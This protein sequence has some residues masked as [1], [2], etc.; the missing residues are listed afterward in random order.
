MQHPTVNYRR[1]ISVGKHCRTAYQ[2]RRITGDSTTHYFDSLRTPYLGLLKTLR[3]GFAALFRRE[4]LEIRNNGT[5]IVDARTGIGFN[6]N[7]AKIPGTNFIDPD[8]IERQYEK[9]KAKMDYLAQRWEQF[10]RSEPVLFIRHDV[11]C[12]EDAHSLYQ[13]LADH[14]GTNP[15]GLLIVTPPDG[16]LAVDHPC[17]FVE[18]KDRLPT[19]QADWTGQDDL[20]DE[21]TARYW[22]PASL[23]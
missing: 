7:F 8:A 1:M 6:H 13:A 22:P 21:I 5:L 9:Q 11:Q 4:D 15:I 20:W 3:D 12:E 16:E 19:G 17:I 10:V 18:R 14:A 23:H 2:I